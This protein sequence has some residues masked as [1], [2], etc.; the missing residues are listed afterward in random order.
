MTKISL[1]KSATDP[2]PVNEIDLLTFYSGIV[3]GDFKEE[4]HE[5][6]AGNIEKKKQLPAVTISGTFEYRST[7]KL[8]TPSG[9]ICIDI[10][11]KDNPD[12]ESMS[13]LRDTIGTWSE[14]EFCSLSASGAGVF[15]VI[16]IA[17]PNRHL[18]QFKALEEVFSRQGIKVDK[19]GK[20]I[21]RLRFMSF[22]PDAIYNDDVK[23]F[24]GL[25]K[26]PVQKP[27]DVEF[28]ETNT[29]RIVERIIKE[30]V[31]VTEDYADWLRV[32]FALAHEFGERGRAYF[33]QISALSSKYDHETCDKKFDNCLATHKSV[34]A[35]TLWHLYRRL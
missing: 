18:E 29:E 13:D 2:N 31:N 25:W 33:H 24:R 27:K 3:T 14:V 11:G 20:D 30:R 4:I 5:I 9:R 16:G 8:K 23:L 12:I 26:K 21:C 7:D 10:D 35:G 19:S 15:A 32:G 1:F 6:R 22:D 17:Y 28:G 34:S